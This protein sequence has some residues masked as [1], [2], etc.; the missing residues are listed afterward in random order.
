MV[1]IDTPC[2]KCGRYTTFVFSPR[3]EPEPK[4]ICK[5]C[6]DKYYSLEAIRDQKL[7]KILQK[8]LFKRFINYICKNI[9]NKN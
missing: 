4:F 2:K 9:V 7:N 3:I 5:S 8:N 1:G 6:H